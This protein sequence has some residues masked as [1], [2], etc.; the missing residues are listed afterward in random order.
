M[1]LPPILPDEEERLAA[2]YRLALLDT[3]AE[4]RFDKI[5]EMVCKVLDVSMSVFSLIDKDRQWFK[6]VQGMNGSETPRQ[7]AFCAHTI[8]GEDMMIVPNA[9]TDERFFDNPAVIGDPY[10]TFYLGCPIHSPEG[11]KVGT[12]CAF[13]T[14]PKTMSLYQLQFIRDMAKLVEME[15]K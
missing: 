2:L 7:Q 6:S 15:I 12:L 9:N 13:D 1:E 14:K 11:K 8:A 10:I 5:T 4:Q 3:P